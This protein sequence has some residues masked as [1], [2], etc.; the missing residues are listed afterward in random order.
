LLIVVNST[1]SPVFL[2]M[3]RAGLVL[4]LLAIGVNLIVS[5]SQL[6]A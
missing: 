6:G 1:H 5:T 4:V 2:P 3:R